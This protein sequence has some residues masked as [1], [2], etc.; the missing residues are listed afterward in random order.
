ML[1]AKGDEVDR[2]L[3]LELGAD[4]YMVKPFS[5]RELVARVRAVLRRARPAEPGRRR[6]PPA[7]STLDPGTYAVAAAGGP[8]RSDAQGVRVAPRAAGR[9]RARAVPRVP[10]RPGLGLRARP[11]E[12][13]SRT[14][15]V[16]VRRLRAKLGGEGRRIVDREGRGLP[17]RAGVVAAHAMRD[18]VLFLRRRI[19]FKLTLTLVGFVGGVVLAAGLYLD[20]ALGELRVGALEARLAMVAPVLEGDA[21]PAGRGGAGPPAVQ[22]FVTRVAAASAAR[23]TLIAADGRVVGRVGRWARRRRQGC[24]ATATGPRCERRSPARSGAISG[25]ARRLD[26]PLLY[27]AVPHGRRRAHRRRA[28]PG[29]AAVGRDHSYATLHQVMLA[30]GAVALVVAFGHRP[31]R[32]RPRDAAGGRDADPS[33]AR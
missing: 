29:P 30:G 24:R 4:D 17:H 10:A 19:A 31:V 7:P 9:A 13:E 18:L 3:G 21:R 25:A 22:A 28:A 33:R 6:W 8:V 12:I 32:R 23:V 5:P 2:V 14:V 27:V 16:H 1:T 26:A 20:Q 11:S 15:D